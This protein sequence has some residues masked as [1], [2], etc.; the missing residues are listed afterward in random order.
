MPTIRFFWRT[1]I[2]EAQ[3]AKIR[4]LP[5]VPMLKNPAT[6]VAHFKNNEIAATEH[7]SSVWR[8]D[9]GFKVCCRASLT[10]TICDRQA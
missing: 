1:S 6:V 7:D 10:A 8:I 5:P 9:R 2:F 3:A 4:W